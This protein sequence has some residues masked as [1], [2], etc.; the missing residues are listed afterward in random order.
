MIYVNKEI[1]ILDDEANLIDDGVTSVNGGTLT[2]SF[3]LPSSKENMSE[4][5]VLADDFSQMGEIN[6]M[7]FEGIFGE[8]DDPLGGSSNNGGNG[9]ED[10][11]GSGLLIFA[12]L[13]II[14]VIVGVAVVIFL[15]R[16]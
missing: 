5:A 8:V 10:G 6:Y 2:I 15:I 4:I 9:D 11:S 16:R 1:L 13:I 14:L 3:N 7:D 12:S